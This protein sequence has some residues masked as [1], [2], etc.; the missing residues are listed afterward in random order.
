MSPSG[1]RRQFDFDI[2][3]QPLN[4]A[5]NQYANASGQPALFPSETVVG[6][7]STA[8]RGRYSAEEALR[9]LLQGTGLAADKRHSDLGRTFVLKKG[10][11]APSPTANAQNAMDALFTEE[12][13]PGLVQAR[14]W[15]A[16]C[17]NAQTRPGDYG[18]LLRF[19]LAADGGLG[20]ARLVA[21]SGNPRRDAALIETLRQV[22][23]ERPPPAAVVRQPVTLS[24]GPGMPTGGLRCEPLAGPG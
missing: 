11:E 21:G 17:A 7:R 1:D 19:Q 2:P 15:H 16:L 13:Y 8:V 24:I 22:R 18:A 6:R 12:G 4:A 5:L 3:A 20:D 14:I 10:G 9:I 23:I